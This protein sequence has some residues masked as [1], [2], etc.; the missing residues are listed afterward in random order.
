VAAS[1]LWRS[2]FFLGCL[3]PLASAAVTS[4][5]LGPLVSMER[6]APFRR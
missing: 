5:R 1:F 3:R 6:P 2:S 4:A